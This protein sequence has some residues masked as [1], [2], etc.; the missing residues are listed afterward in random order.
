[1]RNF[2]SI[3]ILFVA[4]AAV[5]DEVKM[6]ISGSAGRTGSA[7]IVN[8]IQKDGSKYVQLSMELRSTSG[9]IVNIVQESVYDKTGRPIRKIQTTDTKG[10]V[11]QE[12]VAQFE[13]GKVRVRA[14]QNGKTTRSTVFVP[15]GKSINAKSEFW[16]VRDKVPAGGKTTYMR[17]D[18][19]TMD[20]VE[21][22]AV[23]RGTR[24][25]RVG[26]KKVKA[27]LI[28]MGDVKAYVDDRGDPWRVVM[29]GVLM[30][31]VTK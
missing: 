2:L 10:G 17:F 28:E 3:A 5:A 12:I 24:E 15:T 8:R 11:R 13:N 16:F 14:T 27:H 1:M 21:E 23:Y 29:E 30:E 22:T 25:I 4:T 6:T 18:L 7:T 31:R 9:Q 19:Q 20:W 26:G